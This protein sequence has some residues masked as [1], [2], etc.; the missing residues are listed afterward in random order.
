M[1]ETRLSLPPGLSSTYGMCNSRIETNSGSSNSLILKATSVYRRG[2]LSRRPSVSGSTQTSGCLRPDS[3][4][5]VASMSGRL[6][7]EVQDLL[8]RA[9]RMTEHGGA[10]VGQHSPSAVR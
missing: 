7:L 8:L 4:S 1:L 3:A 6:A 2:R 9:L 10:Y 5:T